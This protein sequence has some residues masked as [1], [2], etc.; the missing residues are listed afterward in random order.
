MNFELSDSFA[1]IL[2]KYVVKRF[3]K[4]REA[5]RD[6]PRGP[7]ATIRSPDKT[8]IAYVLIPCNFFQYWH[9]KSNKNLTIP[10]KGQRSSWYHHFNNLWTSSPWCCIPR[11]SLRTSLVPEKK[12]LKCFTIYGHGS[13]IVQWRRTIWTNCQQPFDRRLNVKSSENRWSCFREENI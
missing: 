7:W 13:H 9:S 3:K 2:K 6:I 11:F 8:A 4:K 10:L 1:F 5:L 12:I